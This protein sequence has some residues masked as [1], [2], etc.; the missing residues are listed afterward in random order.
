MEDYKYTLELI[1]EGKKEEKEI[2]LND[3]SNGF[4]I[5]YDT[6]PSNYQQPNPRNLSLTKYADDSSKILM[7]IMQQIKKIDVLRLIYWVTEE[8]E[9][10]FQQRMVAECKNAFIIDLNLN[11]YTHGPVSENYDIKFESISYNYLF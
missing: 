11:G 4:S 7:N 8:N 1:I 6:N 5:P 3:W 10:D 2:I 9:A